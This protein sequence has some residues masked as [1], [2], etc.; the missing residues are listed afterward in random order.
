[1]THLLEDLALAGVSLSPG[2][3]SLTE[4]EPTGQTLLSHSQLETGDTVDLAGT[5]TS[6]SNIQSLILVR[7]KSNQF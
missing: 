4:G 3:V 1:M 7:S 2:T 5:E 6:K